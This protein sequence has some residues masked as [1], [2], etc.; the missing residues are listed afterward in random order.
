MMRRQK[1]STGIQEKYA[2]QARHS[3]YE[4]REQPAMRWFR[5]GPGL[6]LAIAAILLVWPHL[7]RSG[8]GPPRI[9]RTRADAVPNP[10]PGAPEPAWLL[11]Q[12]HALRLSPPQVRKLN[13]LRARWDRD[14]QA[15]RTALAR[16]AAE[17][18]R[19]MVAAGGQR[20]TVQQL[21]ER[22]APVS[23]FSRQL[24]DARRAWWD[25]AATLLTGSQRRRAEQMWARRLSLKSGLDEKAVP[26]R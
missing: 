17:F 10:P 21:Q 25:E 6:L 20:A 12:R 19:S 22:A 5:F 3:Q 8:G 18:D 9:A 26:S 14:T 15:L 11:E 4:R 16:S 24:L 13:K 7:P 2:A 1:R 23:E